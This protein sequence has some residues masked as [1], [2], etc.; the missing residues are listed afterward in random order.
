MG[1]GGE[2][3]DQGVAGAQVLQAMPDADGNDHESGAGVAEIDF[4]DHA[5]GAA[6]FTAVVE[7]GLDIA[8]VDKEA[9]VVDLHDGQAG[10]VPFGAEDFSDHARIARHMEHFLDLHALDGFFEQMPILGNDL[11]I[12]PGCLDDPFFLSMV[13]RGRRP[14]GT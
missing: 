9:G 8:L 11:R 7:H 5:F 1:L 2:V 6:V 13:F 3:E 14:Q 4:V 12:L 10:G